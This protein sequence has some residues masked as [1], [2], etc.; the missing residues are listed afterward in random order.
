MI[1]NI[2]SEFISNHYGKIYFLGI[3]T[4]MI[5]LITFGGIINLDRYRKKELK[6][7]VKNEIEAIIEGMQN[8]LSLSSIFWPLDFIFGGIVYFIIHFNKK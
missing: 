2:L 8:H 7:N 4:H 1:F 5:S 3:I 6:N